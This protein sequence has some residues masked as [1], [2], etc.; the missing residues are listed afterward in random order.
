MADEK[1]R[2]SP[3]EADARFAALVAEHR[4]KGGK[5]KRPDT[6]LRPMPGEA[7]RTLVG[8]YANL[9]MTIVYMIGVVAGSI[10]HAKIGIAILLGVLVFAVRWGYA[11][12]SRSAG[13]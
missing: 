2:L 5:A 11:K 6:G 7:P 1:P 4:R 10:W 13:D 3:E 9:A 8:A 12:F